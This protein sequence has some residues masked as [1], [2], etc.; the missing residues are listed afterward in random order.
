MTAFLSLPTSAQG[1]AC[2]LLGLLVVLAVRLVKKSQ[3]VMTPLNAL[4]TFLGCAILPS[5]PV[6]LSYPFVKAKP[7]LGDHAVFLVL[8][9]LAI[10]WAV[11]EAIRQGLK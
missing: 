10:V 11:Y 3:P 9:A 5:V 7:E 1:A 8:A 6:L 2:G 4:T